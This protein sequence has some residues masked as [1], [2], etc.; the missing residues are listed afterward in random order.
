MS[1]RQVMKDRKTRQRGEIIVY[2][3]LLVLAFSIEMIFLDGMRSDFS[4]PLSLGKGVFGMDSSNQID[5]HPRPAVEEGIDPSHKEEITSWNGICPLIRQGVDGWGS[6]EM[7]KESGFSETLMTSATVRVVNGHPAGGDPNAYFVRCEKGS[8]VCLDNRRGEMFVLTAAHIF[9]DGVG[10]VVLQTSSGERCKGDLVFID[11][12]WDIA[13]IQ[14]FQ[15]LNAETVEISDQVPKRGEKSFILGYGPNDQLKVTTGWVI[16]YSMTSR[17]STYETLRTAGAVRQGDSGG[18]VVNEKNRLIGIVWGT[19]GYA[20]YATWNGR[21]RKLLASNPRFGFC[22]EE[23]GKE[24]ENPPEEDENQGGCE[25]RNLNAP[26]NERG[27]ERSLEDKERDRSDQAS[28]PAKE[29]RNDGLSANGSAGP[30]PHFQEERNPP[31]TRNEGETGRPDSGKEGL[32]ERNGINGE[33][34]EREDRTT[35][36]RDERN[37]SSVMKNA[38]SFLPH[39]PDWIFSALGGFVPVMILLLLPFLKKCLRRKKGTKKRKGPRILKSI[40]LLL[41]NNEYAKELNELYDLNGRNSI[42]D[43][44]CGRLY[45]LELEGAEN[46]TDPVIATYAKNIRRKIKDDLIRIH[47]GT[48]GLPDEPP[49]DSPEE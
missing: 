1:F 2:V 12:T 20:S 45:D 30:D 16:D 15:R 42:A 10:V 43:A 39:S 21:I 37:P 8:G 34:P 7:E 29:N 32:G 38:F 33:L 44:T 25:E 27:P 23:E 41:R 3:L 9:Q 24:A 35:D 6:R 22:L 31:P 14:P 5:F 19:D 40:S 18:P 46:S 48:S 36:N 13:L 47:S 4:F 11:R 17:T 49:S 28:V 26:E